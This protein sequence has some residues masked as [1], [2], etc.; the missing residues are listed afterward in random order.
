MI[1]FFRKIRQNLLS[2]GKTGKYFKYALGEIVLVVI[3]ILIA[4]SI[5]N[6][7][8]NRK[9]NNTIKG[10]YSIIQSDLLSDIETIDKVLVG[11][12]SR[13]SL[14][15]R[16]INK[17]MTY[18]DYLKCNRC[19]RTLGGFPDIKL[20]TK[21]LNLLEQN[22]TVLNSYQD[23]LTIEINNFYSSFNIE[24]DV[25]LQEVIID[26]KEN[27]SYFKNNMT[28]F[29][30]YEKVVFNED[31]VKYALSSIDYRNRVIS[32]YGLYF[33]GYLGHLKQYKEEALLLVETIDKEIK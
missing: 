13:D 19:I 14:F 5:S 9:L 20:K 11:S 29:E 23:S 22:S 30:D 3:G 2:E 4:L 26:F 27:R 7:N 6:W 33:N 12:K 10:I 17:E 31:F 28:W 16:V 24:I 25:A 8:E 15:K 1:K 32:F 21:G 18:D